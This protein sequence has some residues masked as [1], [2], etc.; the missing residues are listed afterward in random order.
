MN[1]KID[2][3]NPQIIEAHIPKEYVSTQ[4]KGNSDIANRNAPISTEAEHLGHP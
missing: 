3:V 2:N 1:T 4:L